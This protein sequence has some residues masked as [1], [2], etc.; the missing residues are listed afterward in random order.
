MYN[1]SVIKVAKLIKYFSD[2]FTYQLCKAIQNTGRNSVD[3][4][5][6]QNRSGYRHQ[7]T[8]MISYWPKFRN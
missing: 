6:L 1:N 4:F 3:N 5:S 2:D 8:K 7:L